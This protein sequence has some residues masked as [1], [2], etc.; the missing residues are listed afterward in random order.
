MKVALQQQQTSILLSITLLDACHRVFYKY[1]E[2]PVCSSEFPSEESITISYEKY[3]PLSALFKSHFLILLHQ[4]LKRMINVL[5]RRIYGKSNYMIITLKY[6]RNILFKRILLW[7]FWDTL[8][9]WNIL[10][11]SVWAKKTEI[12][13]VT[14]WN[15]FTN[16]HEIHIHSTHTLQPGSSS[17]Y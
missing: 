5:W 3:Y 17:P 12:R 7:F 13:N 4:S 1:L 9:N 11:K 15:T 10:F 2:I 16:V 14:S 8:W 6:L